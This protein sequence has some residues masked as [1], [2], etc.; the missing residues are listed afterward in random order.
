MIIPEERVQIK[1]DFKELTT[2]DELA[3]FLK[4]SKRQLIYYSLIL[5]E[6]KKYRK[7]SIPKKSGSFRVIDAPCDTLKYIQ[8]QLAEKLQVLY[9]PSSVAH[10]FIKQYQNTNNQI[11]S[12]G[13][14]SNAQVHIR[15]KNILN[16]DLKDFFPTVSKKRVYGLFKNQY[17]INSK[18]AHYLT[19]LCCTENGLPQGAPTSPIISNMICSR[20]DRKLKSI[21]SKNFVTYSRY[22]DDLSFST[23]KRQFP[24]DF[25]SNL[26]RIIQEEGFNLNEKKRRLLIR[27]NRLEV[28]GLTVNIKTN[29]SRKYV[30]NLRAVFNN[31]NKNGLKNAATHFRQIKGGI[32]NNDKEAFKKYIMGKLEYLGQVKG[33]DDPIFIKFKDKYSDIFEP[34]KKIVKNLMV[35]STAFIK[36]RHDLLSKYNSEIVSTLKVD[37]DE[38]K[39]ISVRIQQKLDKATEIL[40]S[41]DKDNYLETV[42]LL[43]FSCLNEFQKIHFWSET[44]KVEENK[45]IYKNYID[46]ILI[47]EGKY[48][49]KYLKTLPGFRKT[50]Y[51][52]IER[53]EKPSKPSREDNISFFM[54]VFLAEKRKGQNIIEFAWLN[55]IR[56]RLNLTHSDKLNIER[57]NYFERVGWTQC[58][59]MFQ[60]IYFV[61]TKHKIEIDE[62]FQENKYI[63]NHSNE[64]SMIITGIVEEIKKSN[65]GDDLIIIF[66]NNI[67][68]DMH[69]IKASIWKTF[70]K[71]LDKNNE[72]FVIKKKIETEKLYND[73]LKLSIKK[74]DVVRVSVQLS[75]NYTNTIN[76]IYIKSVEKLPE[77]NFLAK[78]E[79]ETDQ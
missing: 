40:L 57:Q 70:N 56:N 73:Y 55:E 29:V 20:L 43:W 68:P 52:T 59:W 32:S 77:V 2:L 74:G 60:F 42:F 17:S 71:T 61:F 46:G 67:S 69:R 51:T 6:N 38:S 63:N 28:T 31:I 16:L 15:K 24:N 13:I 30:R 49:L 21:S 1:N 44:E 65:A 58:S 12:P 47:K 23:S 72:D 48:Y 36:K 79:K 45:F 54:H 64:N 8:K 66:S 14:V 5:P 62:V 26:V 39:N 25:E 19:I 18:I 76:N 37:N 50:S 78:F 33:K 3:I 9:E 22:A 41:P 10:G 7:F 34:E 75:L 35:E 4:T 11:V 53:T 27:E